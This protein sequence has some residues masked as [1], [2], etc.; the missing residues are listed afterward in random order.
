MKRTSIPIDAD[1]QG[2]ATIGWN[3]ANNGY[4]NLKIP[5]TKKM[6]RVNSQDQKLSHTD[7]ASTLIKSAAAKA[8]S[9]SITQ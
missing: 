6:Y 7:S 2:G 8:P 1:M 5:N 3:T 9:F 4:F